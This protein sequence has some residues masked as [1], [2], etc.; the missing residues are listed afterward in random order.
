M[1]AA[2]SSIASGRP[3]SP[4]QISATAGALAAV[5]ANSGSTA[6]ARATNSATAALA[7]SAS[8][9]TA[10]LSVRQLQ[11]RDRHLVLAADPQRVA[12]RHEHL[13]PAG[14]RQQR[15]HRSGGVGDLLEVVEHEQQVL[16]AKVV[17][18][19]LDDRFARA[20]VH[21]QDVGDRL[22][23]E[24]GIGHRRE[25]DE[26]HAAGE[27]VALQR[28]ELDREPG[29]PG[30]PGPVR[31]TTRTSGS[32]RTAAISSSS[33]SRPISGGEGTGSLTRHDVVGRQRR[34][35]APRPV[36][37]RPVPAEAT[38]SPLQEAELRQPLR[39][40]CSWR[41]R[42]NCPA[43]SSRQ[44]A[45]RRRARRTSAHGRCARSVRV[46]LLLELVADHPPLAHSPDAMAPK[47][48]A[49]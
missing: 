28:R 25:L 32:S 27:E 10:A 2:A 30:A 19:G 38:G 17:P 29:L 33:R 39:S 8:G 22:R 15:G 11:R 26:V 3:S 9:A 37:A 40:R 20:V 14:R 5:S 45:A 16:V 49:R 43:R 7:A 34:D 6:W 18:E 42:S 13:Q 48:I 31:V 47:N 35:L 36:H 12:A 44:S 4:M 24:L 23:D 46:D 21:L 1:R 41:K